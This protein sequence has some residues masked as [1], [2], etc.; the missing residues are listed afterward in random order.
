MIRIP[1][2]TLFVLLFGAVNAQQDS[3]Y[4]QIKQMDSI[5]F[6]AGFNQC[7]LEAMA[8]AVSDNFE[9][10]HDEAGITES[11]ADFLKIFEQ[12]IC[13]D[14]DVKPIRKLVENTM[15]VYPMYQNGKLYGAVQSGMHQFYL[16]KGN[17]ELEHTSA[18]RY[19]HLWVL[20]NKQWKLKRVL[21]Y[22]HQKPE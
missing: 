8:S 9:F 12:N 11:K 21:S 14:T 4:E 6:D 18:A 13:S 17:K 20:E 5:I 22:D 10:Y 3:F 15:E 19:T 2:F 16:K 7:Q 1:L